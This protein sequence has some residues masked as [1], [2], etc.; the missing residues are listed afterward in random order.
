MEGAD[1][2]SRVG[3]VGVGEVEVGTA[4][5][6]G[7]VAGGDECNKGSVS[8]TRSDFVFLFVSCKTNELVRGKG[9]EGGRGGGGGRRGGEGGGGE[10][11]RGEKSY[12]GISYYIFHPLIVSTSLGSCSLLWNTFM[13]FLRIQNDVNIM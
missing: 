6:V 7:N 12:H 3:E 2:R 5:D 13:I 10:G 1:G 4:G 11:R 9:V 8:A